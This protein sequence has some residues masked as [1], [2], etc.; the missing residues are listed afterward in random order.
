M[1]SLW[2]R[3]TQLACTCRCPS[4][5]HQK[6][7][8]ARKVSTIAGRLTSRPFTT[9][10]FLYSAIFAAACAVDG[11]AKSQRR[12]QWDDAISKTKQEISALEQSTNERAKSILGSLDGAAEQLQEEVDSARLTLDD[13]IAWSPGIYDKRP[14]IPTS[15]IDYP[16]SENLPP[17]SIYSGP[18]RRKKASEI[19]WTNKKINMTELAIARLVLHMFIAIDID[20]KSGAELEALPESVR[21][22]ASL[23]REE[24]RKAAEAIRMEVHDYVRYLQPWERGVR[25]E[26]PVPPPNYDQPATPFGEAQKLRLTKTIGTLFKDLDNNKIDYQTLVVNISDHL[27]TSPVP[28]S[29]QAFNILVLGFLEQKQR[30]SRFIMIEALVNLCREAYYRPNEFTCAGILRAYRLSDRPDKFAKF[31]SLMRAKGDSLMLARP[32]IS[33][34]AKSQG[35]LVRKQDKI[36]QAVQPSTMVYEEMILGVLKYVGFDAA[37]D[38]IRNLAAEAWG[39]DWNCLYGLMMD[40]V[41]RR[42]WEDGLMIW[43]QMKVL[44][45]KSRGEMPTRIHG[46]KLALCKVCDR[47]EEFDEQFERAIEEGKSPSSVLHWATRAFIAA[48]RAGDK[49]DYSDE[50]MEVPSLEEEEVNLEARR[51]LKQGLDRHERASWEGVGERNKGLIKPSPREAA[52]EAVAVPLKP[53]DTFQESPTFD[54]DRFVAVYAE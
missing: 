49:D 50:D 20:G 27:L 37:I 3:A 53:P 10:T 16:D 42:A 47:I 54:E 13:V 31:V 1:Q 52:V 21:P 51:Q 44:A 24:Q 5:L 39:L 41:A 11:G 18:I 17:Q 9:G 36:L 28:P 23:S 12:K 38:I 14:A 7:S 8:A 2:T 46:V 32:D 19:P 33:I 48:E 22:F 45:K 34:N 43:T 26:L 40:C 29:L 15:T 30:Q 25:R 35:R 4:C 6:V